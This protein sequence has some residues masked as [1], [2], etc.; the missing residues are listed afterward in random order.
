METKVTEPAAGRESSVT[1]T[2]G[3]EPAEEPGV[4]AVVRREG[5][6]VRVLSTLDISREWHVL[7]TLSSAI[8]VMLEYALADDE[9][10][11]EVQ[12]LSGAVLAA[13]GQPLYTAPLDLRVDVI[14]APTG[15]PY[16][17]ILDASDDRTWR[18]VTAVVDCEDI[19]CEY[20]QDESDGAP[21]CT[22]LVSEA[23]VHGFTHW[24]SNEFLSVR[25]PASVT[26]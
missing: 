23:Y 18:D 19:N 12:L 25:I 14:D 2:I 1:H 16:W 22:V 15:G 10:E 24:P 9:P 7:Q 11:A 6:V 8:D 4:L 13:L 3:I 26:A 17:Q 21:G 20:G 5:D